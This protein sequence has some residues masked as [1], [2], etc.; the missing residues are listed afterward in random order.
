MAKVCP[1]ECLTKAQLRHIRRD[2]GEARAKGPLN[3]LNALRNLPYD[4]PSIDKIFPW[5]PAA[6]RQQLS[7]EISRNVSPVVPV[8]PATETPPVKSTTVVHVAR[9]VK[10]DAPVAPVA[11]AKPAKKAG[12][13]LDIT[14]ARD[15][16]A[17]AANSE[18]AA[19][20]A[21]NLGL[22]ETTVRDIIKGRTWKEEAVTA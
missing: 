15:I 14:T 4:G 16:R 19:A 5:T 20:I 9:K 18:S 13:K 21:R 3:L 10:N 12:V 7:A 6:T 1:Q 2:L 8:V 22:G 17:R 11:P